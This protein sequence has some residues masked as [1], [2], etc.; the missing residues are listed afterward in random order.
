MEKCAP[1]TA[2]LDVV[3]TLP[4]TSTNTSIC[5][6]LTAIGYL[7]DEKSETLMHGIRQLIGR[8]LPTPQEV[9]LLHGLAR[10]LLWAARTLEKKGKVEG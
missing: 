8:A 4:V 7:F 5:A 1:R 3:T 6:R 2:G 10:Q 9:K